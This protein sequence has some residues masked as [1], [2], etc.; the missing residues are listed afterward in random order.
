MTK[1]SVETADAKAY[2]GNEP[3]KPSLDALHVAGVHLG[4]SAAWQ[5]HLVSQK[6][7]I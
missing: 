2:N 5:D 1:V 7:Q 4:G 6:Y 3:C